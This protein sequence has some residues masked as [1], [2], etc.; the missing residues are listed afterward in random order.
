MSRRPDASTVVQPKRRPSV[1]SGGSKTPDVWTN[2]Q[3]GHAIEA[4][5]QGLRG[6]GYELVNVLDAPHQLKAL[7]YRRLPEP[8]PLDPWAPTEDDDPWAIPQPKQTDVVPDELPFGLLQLDERIAQL[9]PE[10]RDA[11]GIPPKGAA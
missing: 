8:E 11:L 10:Q 4:A 6:D 7:L 3:D 5:D 2:E 9:T 1:Q